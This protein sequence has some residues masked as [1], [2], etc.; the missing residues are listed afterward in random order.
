M[1][2][3]FGWINAV[4]LGCLMGMETHSFAYGMLAYYALN[5]LAEIREAR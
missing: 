1:K 3:I 5:L 2:Q 4:L